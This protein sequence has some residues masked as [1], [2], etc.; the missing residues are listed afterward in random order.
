MIQNEQLLVEALAE[1]LLEQLLDDETF[2][3]LV[4][5]EVNWRFPNGVRDQD[6]EEITCMCQLLVGQRVMRKVI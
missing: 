6:R 5:Q 1:R 4:D 3:L 2:Q